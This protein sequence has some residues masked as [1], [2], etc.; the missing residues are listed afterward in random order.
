MGA[1]KAELWTQLANAIKAI[2]SLF[3]NCAT[4]S[5]NFLG[6]INTLQQSY[7]GAHINNTNNGFNTLINQMSGICGS[8]SVLD[9][10]IVELARV[11]YNSQ[12]TTASNALDDIY[13]GMLAAS[14]TVKHRNWTADTINTAAINT[15][16]GIPYRCVTDEGT[17]TIESGNIVGGKIVAKIISDQSSGVVSGNEPCLIA[18]EGVLPT[19]NIRYGDIP[20]GSVQITAKKAVDG[21]LSNANFATINDDG[22]Y[23]TFDSWTAGN[24]TKATHLSYD[25]AIYFRKIDVNTTGKSAK[26]IA[27]NT[28][29][30][31]VSNINTSLPLFLIVRYYRNACDGALTIN[32]GSQSVSVADLTAVADTT[33]HDLA[34][35]DT[36]K[37]WY[38]VYKES[39]GGAGVEIGIE[40]SGHST[41]TLLLGEIILAQPTFFNGAYYLL[42]AGATDFLIG[43]NWNW[44][45]TVANTGRIQTTLARLYRKYLPY[46]AGTPTFADA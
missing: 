41:G 14:E 23:V 7:E 21:L 40:L 19:D 2:D 32:I 35:V 37:S 28:L 13:R 24:T 44:T 11:G 27:D 46:T 33:W 5:P 8:S 38:P 25:T 45:D 34:I 42:T 15:G 6:L 18:G 1:S 16:T 22:T 17:L 26:F 39:F 12:A 36:A 4:D 10:L 29:K 3:K 43:D 9:S 20:T 30:Q 31:W